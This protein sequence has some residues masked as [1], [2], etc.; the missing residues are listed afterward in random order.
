MEK[1]KGTENCCLEIIT[2]YKRPL[3][4]T[5]NG[6]VFRFKLD[7]ELSESIKRVA[8]NNQSTLFMVLFT[9]F[10][11]LLNKITRKNDFN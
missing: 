5:N 6:D 3:I 10:N 1:L 4:H 8:L 9:A 11:I 2:D 7:K